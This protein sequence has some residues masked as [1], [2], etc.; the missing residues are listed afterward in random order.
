MKKPE[1]TNGAETTATQR[2]RIVWCPPR[3]EIC[4]QLRTVEKAL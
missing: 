1:P 2:P 3:A 4:P